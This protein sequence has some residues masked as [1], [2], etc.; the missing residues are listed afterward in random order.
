MKTIQIRKG[1]WHWWVAKNFG[2]WKQYRN[3][4][5]YKLHNGKLWF[6]GSITV[7]NDFCSYARRFVLGSFWLLV[8]TTLVTVALTF[9]GIMEYALV[10]ALI[11][12]VWTKNAGTG[13]V[14]LGTGALSGAVIGFLIWRD[15]SKWERREARKARQEAR[16]I[17]KLKNK[18]RPSV[19]K[20]IWLS[21]KDKTCFRMEV[22]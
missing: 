19:L 12:G 11:S 10:K 6:V 15:K 16:E 4:E 2:G 9:I 18:E 1:S 13:V 21:I 22:K 17:E 7:E 20:H 5:Q 3:E 8:L 14:I